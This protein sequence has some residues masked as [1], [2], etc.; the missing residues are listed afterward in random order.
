MRTDLDDSKE[1]KAFQ[2]YY[3]RVFKSFFF[4]YF[5]VAQ[6]PKRERTRVDRSTV[7]LNPEV[8]AVISLNGV[9]QQGHHRPTASLNLEDLHRQIMEGQGKENVAFA[10]KKVGYSR[11]LKTPTVCAEL[12]GALSLKNLSFWYFFETLNE[13]QRVVCIENCSLLLL[14]GYHG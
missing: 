12:F 2:S 9:T 4:P 13:F 1:E 3:S 14:L 5:T 6:F 11:H 8:R 7:V 10:T